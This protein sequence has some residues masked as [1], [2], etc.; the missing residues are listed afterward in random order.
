MKDKNYQE[1][2]LRV[3]RQILTDV[4]A[5][6]PGSRSLP[7]IIQNIESR[8]KFYESKRKEDACEHPP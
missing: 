8:I 6:Y 3:W 2:R 4:Q 5:E 7:N 1:T